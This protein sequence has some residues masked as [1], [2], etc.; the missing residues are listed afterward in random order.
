[1]SLTAVVGAIALLLAANW[2]FCNL[3]AFWPEALLGLGF[4][5]PRWAAIALLLAVLT[6]FVD[7][8]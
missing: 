2:L 6:A 3:F 5:L 7:D 8:A 1:M 4:G